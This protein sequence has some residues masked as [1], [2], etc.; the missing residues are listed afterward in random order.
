MPDEFVTAAPQPQQTVA[1]K[2]SSESIDAYLSHKPA[3]EI[4]RTFSRADVEH[5]RSA[6]V[7]NDAIGIGA[8]RSAQPTSPTFAPAPAAEVDSAIT[9]L[10]SLGGDHAALVHEW[11]ST[12]ANVGEEISYAR[13]AYASV[14]A[15][16]RALIEAV[17]SSG[18]GNH[19]SVL[20]FL[21]RM[22]RADANLMGDRTIEN[23]SKPSRLPSPSS[24]RGN[25]SLG[26]S[27][28]QSE[29]DAL[30]AANPVGSASYRDPR[31]QARIQHLHEML[32]SGSPVGIGGRRA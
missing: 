7:E 8:A 9:K 3:A 21:A 29:L 31:V 12:G 28:T 2:A 15:N 30:Y 24:P 17:D 1:D 14:A 23:R 11:Q 25:P 27:E 10:Q 5:R 22:G 6:P 32:N 18:L 26:G 19:P 4:E 13:A 16:D 20:K